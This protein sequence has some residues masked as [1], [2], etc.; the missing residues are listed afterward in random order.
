MAAK[1]QGQVPLTPVTYHTLLSLYDGVKHGYGVKREVE[2]RTQGVVRLGAGTL[3]EAIQRL[4][5]SGLIEETSAPE[6]VE[7][8]NARWRFYRLTPQGRE[9][10]SAELRRLEADVKHAYAKGL[11]QN[12]G[13][14]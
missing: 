9:V 3:Y 12:L 10:L 2:H 11:G 5:R 1:T 8:E 7:V 14:V 13:G 4:G 6:D